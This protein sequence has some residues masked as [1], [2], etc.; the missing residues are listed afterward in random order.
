MQNPGSDAGVFVLGPNGLIQDRFLAAVIPGRTVSRQSPPRGAGPESILPIVVMDSG[1]N[2]SR[3]P[4]TTVRFRCTINQRL[5]RLTGS[6]PP[7]MRGILS[8]FLT[9]VVIPGQ[10]EA[11]SYDVQLHIRES[12]TTTV[13]L[14]YPDRDRPTGVLFF[15]QTNLPVTTPLLEFF[16]ARNCRRH[17]VVD[18]EPDKLVDVTTLGEARHGFGA[19]LICTAHQI[20]G[21]AEIVSCSREGKRKRTSQA[22][23]VMDSGLDALRRPE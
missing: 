15:D 3:R 18:F 22:D 20:V 13:S 10:R 21:H 5:C 12:I 1:L 16:L 17:I 7:S 11:S 4:G 23:V 2:A 6:I 9:P 14:R 8:T 19:M